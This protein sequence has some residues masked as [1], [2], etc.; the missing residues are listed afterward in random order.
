MQSRPIFHSS[1]LS[2][3]ILILKK[4]YNIMVPR[5]L[6]HFMLFKSTEAKHGAHSISRRVRPGHFHMFDTR[7]DYVLSSQLAGTVSGDKHTNGLRM[8]L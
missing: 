8:W 2:K 4:E 5:S 7:M 6:A 1:L 3:D